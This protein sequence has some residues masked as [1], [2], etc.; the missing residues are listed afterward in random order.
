MYLDFLI[1]TLSTT[2]PSL[3]GSRKVTSR[4]QFPVDRDLRYRFL[5]VRNMARKQSYRS[6]A[7]F[8]FERQMSGGVFV[9]NR[10]KKD[11]ILLILRQFEVGKPFYF[12]FWKA[13]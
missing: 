12:K 8:R 9:E 13:C 11:E 6:L 5:Y 1:L 4:R 7:V 2:V 10:V 3:P